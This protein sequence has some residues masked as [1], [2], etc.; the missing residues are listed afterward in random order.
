[1]RLGITVGKFVPKTYVQRAADNFD[2]RE[3]D[4]GLRMILDCTPE[5]ERELTGLLSAAAA[6]NILVTACTG[7]TRR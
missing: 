6:R 5:L 3:H 7:R 1:M 2:F 4:D